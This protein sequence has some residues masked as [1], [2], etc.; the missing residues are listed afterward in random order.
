MYIFNFAI[1][2]ITSLTVTVAAL[3]VAG[4]QKLQCPQHAN[5]SHQLPSATAT[6]ILSK[7]CNHNITFCCN[8]DYTLDT[9]I[10]TEV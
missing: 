5:I 4:L 9:D 1:I 6:L 2:K 10:K 3:N 8:K 7:A